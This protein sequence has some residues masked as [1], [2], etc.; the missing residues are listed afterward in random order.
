MPR[1]VR[2]LLLEC[3]DGK[4]PEDCLFTRANGTPVRDFRRSWRKACTEAGVPGLHF[5]DLRRTAARN[6]RRGHISERVA[7]EIGG[8]KTTSVFHRYAIVDNQDVARAMDMLETSQN[9]QR[10][11]LERALVAKRAQP[12]V[13]N[14]RNVTGEGQTKKRA[15]LAGNSPR[16]SR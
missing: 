4:V 7:M 1:R 3:I 16:T 6:M 5:R 8:W 9:E 2:E 12:I 10:Q 13:I 15:N 14:D 11:E